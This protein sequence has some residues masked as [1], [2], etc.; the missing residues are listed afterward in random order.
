MFHNCRDEKLLMMNNKSICVVNNNLLI[1]C[2]NWFLIITILYQHQPLSI[3]NDMDYRHSQWLR[4][5]GCT[6]HLESTDAAGRVPHPRPTRLLA[7]RCHVRVFF[8]D[9]RRLGSICADAARFAPNR[10][11]FASNRADSARI[12]PYRPYRMVSANDQYGRYGQNRPETAE[13]G[14]ETC[15]NNRNSDLKCVF[16]L[17]L[18]SFCESRHGNVFFKNILI[19]KIFLIIF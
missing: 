17:L 15:R 3:I 13:I 5:Q 6:I 10:L 7:R 11:R 4:S 16:C 1:I 19:V 14:L 18:S 9:L 12:E 2:E 8:L